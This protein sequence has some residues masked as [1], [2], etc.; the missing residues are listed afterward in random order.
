LITKVTEKILDA[1][2][3]WNASFNTFGTTGTNSASF[4][5]SSI[6]PV[7]LQQRLG[8]LI[9]YPHGCLEQVTSSVFPQLYLSSLTDLSSVRKAEVSRNI[10]AGILRLAGF[11]L[12]D[13]GMSYWPGS[14]TA[15]EWSTSYSGHFMIEAETAGYTLPP[16]FLPQWKKFQRSKAVSWTPSTTDFYG[17]DLLQAYRL[18]LLALAR[19]PE[20]GAMNRL[21][22][23][24]YLSPAGKWRLAAAYRIAGQP[25][26]A[27]SLIKGLPLSVKPYRQSYG[28]FGSDLRDEAMI[29]E[30][31]TLMNMKRQS[32]ALVRSIAAR[33]SQQS[34]YST[35]STA[36]ALIAVS[37]YCGNTSGSKLQFAYG[38][39]NS[40][41]NVDSKAFLWQ[42]RAVLNAS[43]NN[44]SIRNKGKN[45]LFVRLI[46]QGKPA[47]GQEAPSENNPDVLTMR[48]SYFSLNGKLV[49]PSK[50]SQGTDFVAQ[51]NIYNPGKRGR[52]TNM[53]VTQIFPSGWEIINTRLMNQENI[54]SSSPADYRDIRDD[55]VN[56]YFSIEEGKELTYFILLNASYPGKYYLPPVYCEAMYD[57]SINASVK[58]QWVEVLPEK[59]R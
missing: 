38:L 20:L 31:L 2:A 25:E 10:K 23:F 51:V 42:Q 11:Q 50:L 58:G 54:F 14:G 26:V 29:L 43:K 3:S 13:G 5:V 52:Y 35:Q 46:T 15:D 40:K 44:V 6:P 32:A 49:D 4:E 19:S 53:A 48:V 33:L 56:T 36:Y 37:K 9:R 22:E 47:I 41:G 27:A 24:K 21:R 8:Y 16:A 7:N 55:R 17:G 12:P 45:R 59:Y 39:N 34:W 30:T 57:S 18:Y 28:T 1:G